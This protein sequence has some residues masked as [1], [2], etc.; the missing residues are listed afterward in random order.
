MIWWPLQAFVVFVAST[1]LFDAVHY[2]LH[3]W[4]HSR[5]RL[6]RKF[7]AMHQVH[8]R[9]LDRG[10]RIN[11]RLIK[12]NFWAHILPEYLTS[13]GGTALF[14][15]VFPW[16]PVAGVLA[17]HTILF[18]MSF[19][20]EGINANHMAM[21]RVPGR[22][23]VFKVN[24]AYHAMHHI[25]PTAFFSSYAN[26]FDMIFGTALKLRG[27][28]VT[29]LGGTGALGRALGMKLMRQGAAVQFLDR[30]SST[31]WVNE[32]DILILATGSRKFDDAFEANYKVPIEAGELFIAACKDRLVPPEIWGIGSEA[33]LH[34]GDYYAHT[35]T[36]FAKYVAQNWAKNPDVT[37]R[38]VV[39]SAF[40]SKM[41]WGLMSANTVAAITIFLAKRGFMYIP[42]T[43]TGLAFWNRFLFAA[44]KGGK[45]HVKGNI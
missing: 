37:Y 17:F 33:E 2:T 6:L 43:V 31:S 30:E 12:A 19:Y 36:E 16:Q 22:R 14:L 44:R 38:H 11:K 3:Q 34:G 13:M 42:V 7:S 10:M 32:A 28:R 5:V 35:K 25:Q 21:D 1:T 39:P 24:A 40:R 23:G 27:Q 26:V 18:A 20:D 8:H 15:L 4:A 41:G 45:S 29:I 9:F